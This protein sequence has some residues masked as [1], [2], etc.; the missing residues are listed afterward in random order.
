MEYKVNG[1]IGSVSP[2]TAPSPAI[3]IKRE[4]VQSFFDLIPGYVALLNKQ[5][6][7]ILCSKGTLEYFNCKNEADLMQC[8]LQRS[9]KTQENGGCPKEKLAEIAAKALEFGVAESGWLHIDTDGESV[10][11]HI[12]MV[13]TQADATPEEPCIVLCFHSG[14]QPVSPVDTGI[15]FTN[16]LKAI[17]D[18][19]PLALNLWDAQ[20]N[21]VV[22]NKQ[23]LN[24]FGAKDEA[25]YLNNFSNFSP[26]YQP[27]GV[28]SSEMFKRNIETV[29]RE[30]VH[31]F[32]WMH[33]DGNGQELPA[34]I[35]LTKINVGQDE[36]NIVGFVR[37]LRPEFEQM[38][39]EKEDEYY[40]LNRISEKT[41]LSKVAD[42]SDDLFFAIDRRTSTIRFL[43]HSLQKSTIKIDGNNTTTR[44]FDESCVHEEDV[45]I[46][47]ELV[48]NMAQGINTPLELRFL[49]PDGTFRY[50]R[51]LYCFIFDKEGK[52]IIVIGK[53]VDIH[54]Q[55]MLQ[56]QAKYDFLTKCYSRKN[57]EA[58]I[59]EKLANDEA[60]NGAL[61][62]VD[63]RNFK[64]FNEENGHFYGDEILRQLVIRIK[65]WCSKRDVVGRVGGDEFI[66]YVADAQ[67]KNQFED[68]LNNLIEQINTSYHIHEIKAEICVSV[69]VFLC[70]N[71]C[72]TYEY[73]IQCADKALSMAKLVTKGQWL[74]YDDSYKEHTP[75]ILQQE[76]KAEKISGL[77]MNYTVSSSIF[78]ILYERNSDET[79]INSAL[80]YWGQSYHASRC[81]IM[82]TFDDGATYHFTHEWCKQGFVPHMQNTTPIPA[83]VLSELMENTSVHGIFACED[84]CHC[85]LKNELMQRIANSDTKSFLHAQVKKDEIVTFF[86]GI[87]DCEKT[88][89]WTDVEINTLHYMVRVFSIILQA[90][91]LDNEVKILSEHSKIAAFV[92]GNTDNFIYIVDPDTYEIIYMNK[93]ALKMY[94]NP[95]ESE[96]RSKKCYELLHDKVAPCEFCTNAYTTEHDFYEWKYYNPR[97]NKSYLFKDKL[98]HLNG[99]LVKLQVATDITTM[100]SL[101][102][103][104][105]YKLEEQSL[106]LNCIQMLHTSE[107]PDASIE[108]ILNMICTFF[109]ASRGVILQITP[110]GRYACNTHEWTDAFTTEHKHLWKN[111][112]MEVIQA[113]FDKFQDKGV[114][115]VADV[116]EEFKQNASV[117]GVLKNQATTHLACAPILNAS[118]VYIGLLS[119][120]NPKKNIDKYWLLESLSG[121]VSDFLKKNKL[122][123]SL[124][125][126]SY[127]DTLTKVKN[128]HSYRKA[129]QD[130]D[131]GCVSSLGV[132]YVDISGLS[133]INE[134]K[135]TR[136]GDEIIKRMARILTEV[137]GENIF[138][139]GGDEFVVL[140][141]NVEELAFEGK[142]SILKNAIF[143]E[144]ELNATIGFTWNTNIIDEQLQNDNSEFNTV[145][146]SQT[147]TAIL[148]KN[149]ENEIKS[150]KYVV[151]LQ[152][153]ICFQTGEL[154]GA[155][156]L[157]RRVDAS[158]NAQ[159]PAS[160]VPFY[161]KEG[162]I[163]KIDLHVFET[164]CKLLCRW[165][166]KQFGE[167]IKLS[168]NCSRSTVMEKD[169]VS[170]LSDICE[171]YAVEKSMFVIEITETITHTDDKLFSYVMTSLKNAGFCV[172]LDDFG[173]GQSNLSSLQISDFD[174]IK[175]DMGLTRDIHLDKK[176]RILTKVALNLCQEFQNM[177]SVAEGIETVEQFDILK[178]LNCH[179][180][181]GYYFSKPISIQDF[182]Q[183]Y[184][185]NIS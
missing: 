183:K 15:Q 33:L 60:C 102:E 177:V 25:E 12:N 108:K 144:P 105:K 27:N 162:M 117:R 48:D 8:F 141:K 1:T 93:K 110:D 172:S 178:G 115:Y 55:K 56:E 67:N 138:R 34:E 58:I 104:L 47:R 119:I 13:C 29:T 35:T 185:G 135:G 70:R 153:Q 36:D 80:R 86:I 132:A 23:V 9:A 44:S 133:R 37:D 124:N 146:D 66:I 92:G 51:I 157:I 97:F 101:E 85:Q 111:V 181:Q 18:A 112:E 149:L 182:E 87:E 167:N 123:D 7:V 106:L 151:F 41:L 166:Q 83:H 69:G 19:T 103:M 57:I 174:E 120:D 39:E 24:I 150:G 68:R 43:G 126:L 53:G 42:I 40:F 170:K 4:I 131:E 10:P 45:P 2:N 11:M 81:F 74:Y 134:E 14:N 62:F 32:K 140:E 96:W 121:F 160:F 128:R 16:M 78:N 30:G 75:S 52:P 61:L 130:I 129:L 136:Y 176:A 118:G 50:Y 82:E 28:L 49:Q 148:S 145:W 114:F 6:E 164:A 142:I 155:E 137:F 73:C 38:E 20:M 76:H 90:K 84:I 122:I 46:Y 17:V 109:D 152:P 21:N 107:T 168:V 5:L 161:E 26:E 22:C 116:A 77:Q 65:Q 88:R 163:S 79:A 184:F 71:E 159:S 72:H 91:H 3:V 171:K 173:A 175:I 54:E 113:F 100:V 179:M 139:V 158:G 165:K 125:E 95:S 64:R 143:E 63:I 98:V 156:A 180:G 89:V 99:K 169:I 94:N 59:S 154:G 147:Y 31:R 127:Y